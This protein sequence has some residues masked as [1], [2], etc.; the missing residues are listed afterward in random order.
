MAAHCP[1]DPPGTRRGRDRWR[2]IGSAA[3]RSGSHQVVREPRD[4]GDVE[5]TVRCSPGFARVVRNVVASAAA[6]AGFSVDELDDLRLLADEGFVALCDAGSTTVR[7][8]VDL[9]G[10]HVTIELRGDRPAEPVDT[11]A[12]RA[13]A[14]VLAVRSLVAF[15][16]DPPR[17][18]AT[19]RASAIG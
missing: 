10:D 4:A 18:A 1:F 11:S 7:V 9:D 6:L 15:D 13:L 3:F 12:L 19:L 17:L 16:E 5:M 2:P 14:T 8:R